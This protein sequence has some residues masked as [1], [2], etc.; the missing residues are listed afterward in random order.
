MTYS[1]TFDQKTYVN[2]IYDNISHVLLKVK[3]KEEERQY[4][5]THTELKDWNMSTLEESALSHARVIIA[6]GKTASG[7]VIE[8]GRIQSTRTSSRRF[9]HKY[10][11]KIRRSH[12]ISSNT[13]PSPFSKSDTVQN[14]LQLLTDS[15][16]EVYAL[17]SSFAHGLANL[18][19]E[20]D[21]IQNM[22]FLMEEDFDSVDTVVF[23]NTLALFVT[24]V[25]DVL[26]Y[27][28]KT[29]ARVPHEYVQLCR[30]TNSCIR[31]FLR[32]F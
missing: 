30:L 25:E 1:S 15:N 11:N 13:R 5:L 2:M 10:P 19:H 29:D 18:A 6:E 14:N 27:D 21:Y 22:V 3:L 26:K 16:S 12:R 4:R 20:N 24:N 23:K 28:P 17:T 7:Q 8:N 31:H 32:F 9:R